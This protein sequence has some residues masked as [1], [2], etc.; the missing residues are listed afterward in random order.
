MEGQ[1]FCDNLETE[2]VKSE[3]SRILEEKAAGNT[4]PECVMSIAQALE[5]E[6]EEIPLQACEGKISA[7]YLYIYPPGIPIIAPGERVSKEVLQI[8]LDYQKCG[9]KLHGLTEKRKL[10]VIAML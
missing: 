4:H 6:Q 2:V 8:C 10:K 9:L 3:A 1:N 7:A 5:T